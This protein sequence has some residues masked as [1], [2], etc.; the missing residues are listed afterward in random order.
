MGG[1]G[2]GGIFGCTELY[3]G[4][5]WSSGASI[6]TSRSTGV[7]S[8]TQNAAFLAGGLK[9]ADYVT[10]DTE[11]Y[12]GI[13]YGIVGSL[14]TILHGGTGAGASSTDSMTF[15]GATLNPP[16]SSQIIGDTSIWNC[17]LLFENYLVD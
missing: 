13:T 10:S 14:P 15:G 11:E 4:S 8:G 3:D 9:D 17:L 16:G 5:S 1:Q 2:T 12:N 7:G 6:I